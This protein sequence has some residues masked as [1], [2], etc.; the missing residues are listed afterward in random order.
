MADAGGKAPV[1]AHGSPA[2]ASQKPPS[3]LQASAAT[4]PRKSFSEEVIR[5][6]FG[7]TPIGLYGLKDKMINITSQASFLDALLLIVAF[8]GIM[9]SLPFYPLGVAV[10]IILLLFVC[11]LLNPFL[12]LLVYTVLIFPVYMY[13]TPVLAW[14]FILGATVLLIFG[15]M[16]YRVAVF[17][18]ILTAFAFSPLGYLFEIPLFLL[19]VLTIGNKRTVFTLALAVFLIALFSAVTGMQNTAYILYNAGAAHTALSSTANQ[20]LV[21]N[22]PSKPGFTLS[23]FSSAI[24]SAISS[25]T[26]SKVTF[27]ISNLFGIAFEALLIGSFGYIIQ[28][29]ALVGAVLAIDWYAVTNRSK[30]KGAA[31]SMFGII[32]P[33]V[34]VVLAGYAQLTPDLVTPFLSFVIGPASF[35]MLEYYEVNIVKSLDV[36]KQDIRMRFGEAFEDLGQ[37][38][39]DLTFD[40]IGNYDETKKELREAIINPIEQR[41]I[42]RAYNV[43][44]T[45]GILFFGPPGTG[46]T[47]MMRALSKEIHGGFYYVKAS[48]L[49]SAFPGETENRI[50]KIFSIAKKN[51]PCILFFDEIDSLTMSREVPG[52]DDTHRHALSQLLVEMDGFSKVQNVIIVGATNR[53][54]LMDAAILR[55]GRFD[56]LIYMP[57]PDADGRKKIFKKYLSKLPVSQTLNLNEIAVNTERYSGADIKTLTE[58][59]AQVVARD[60]TAKH[61]VLEI[62]QQDI[63]SAARGAKPSTTLAQLDAYKRFKIDFERS[64]FKN[65]SGGDEEKGTLMDDVIGQDV[66]KKA[67]REAIEIPLTHPELIKKYGI[68]TIN[69]LLLF[70]PPG[71]GKTMLMKAVSTEMKGVTMLELNGSEI[72]EAGIEKGNVTI[73]EMFNRAKENAPSVIFIDEVESLLPK[74]QGA[75]EV[76]AQITSEVLKQI[77]GIKSMSNVVVI[78]A[79]NTPDALDTAILRPG[80]FDKIILIR[81]PSAAG[82]SDMFKKYLSEVPVD[83]DID[84]AKLGKMT[85]GFTGADIAN[86]C[87]EAKTQSLESEVSTGNETPISQKVLESIVTS[88]KPSAPD[89]VMQQ[90]QSFLTKF[91][92]R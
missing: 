82:R 75:S 61:T 14:G 9:T 10:F 78:G 3:P 1:T 15:Y 23:T 79:T 20:M 8:I 58:S 92:E 73:K 54:D 83:E 80:R 81:P 37:G 62:S 39:P 77:D 55:P 24:P 49:I 16:H 68:K 89:S 45:K 34:Y 71:N 21:I 85:P 60:A 76:S 19:A 35:Y 91:G 2:A 46:K 25:F 32:Y 52:V 22:T 6:K 66:A 12:G 72:S 47:M 17:A 84:Y 86:V 74:R 4:M 51:I 50:S 65:D 70:G 5:K 36:R 67:I 28:F 53:P 90:Y 57:L 42:S 31:A 48:N 40:D 56:K 18:Y 44:P 26:S 27:Q 13:Q 29:V 33:I 63:L 88:V 11:A 30:F 7:G 87:R 38:D 69:G 59:V 41:A 43:Q 64:M